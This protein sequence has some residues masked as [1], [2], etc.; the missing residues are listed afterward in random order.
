MDLFIKFRADIQ[1][2]SALFVLL[3]LSAC[4]GPRPLEEMVLAKVAIK[5]A[6]DVGSVS[7]AP[8]YWYK[9][10]EN[11]RKG[12]ESLKGNYNYDAK[13]FFVQAKIYAEKAENSTRL[14]KFNSG[15]NYP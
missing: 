6:Q 12:L 3:L 8:G 10:E 1:K 13:E 2:V 7:I 14:K 15:E 4:A 5:A 9:A 11:Y